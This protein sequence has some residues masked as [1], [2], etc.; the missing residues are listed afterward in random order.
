MCV[1]ACVGMYVCMYIYILFSL[2]CF[3]LGNYPIIN[4]LQES[5]TVFKRRKNIA[6]SGKKKNISLEDKNN[7]SC[8]KL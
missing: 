8:P 5:N 2:V 6:Y 7:Y 3:Q 1:Y 4:K